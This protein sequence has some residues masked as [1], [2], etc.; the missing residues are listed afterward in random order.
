MPK[1]F[2]RVMTVNLS[3]IAAVVVVLLILI[4]LLRADINRRTA[5][6]VELKNKVAL[7]YK[8]IDSLASLQKD[9]EKARV[10]KLSLITTLPISD[11]L[12]DFPRSINSLAK[13]NDVDVGFSFG[14]EVLGSET[15][16]GYLS[17]SITADAPFVNWLNFVSSIERSPYVVSFDSFNLV[18]D[19]KKFKSIINGK[20]FSQ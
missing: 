16:P 19:E 13:K 9:S 14:R 5:K 12:I 2:K 4:A 1:D 3:V 17:F 20:V 7:R 6:V 8:A 15:K 11:K 18:G 10:E